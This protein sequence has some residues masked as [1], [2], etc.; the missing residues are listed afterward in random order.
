L[1]GQL[2]ATALAACPRRQGPILLT[3]YGKGFAAAGFGNYMADKV[4]AAGCPSA[5]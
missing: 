4:E 3:Q 1:P 5:A 2:L